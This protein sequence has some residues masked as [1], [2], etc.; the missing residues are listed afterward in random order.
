MLWQEFPSIRQCTS[1][2][3]QGSGAELVSHNNKCDWSTC[4]RQFWLQGMQQKLLQVRPPIATSELCIWREC[5]RG[6]QCGHTQQLFNEAKPRAGFFKILT[7]LLHSNDGVITAT[8]HWK[9]CLYLSIMY[10]SKRESKQFEANLASG[11][12]SICILHENDLLDGH[13]R[14]E[15]QAPAGDQSNKADWWLQGRWPDCKKP[16]VQQ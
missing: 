10:S 13:N 12:V 4:M 8:L 14:D 5:L 6:K 9:R 15:Q 7:I 1:A 16:A 11:C 2:S 3:C